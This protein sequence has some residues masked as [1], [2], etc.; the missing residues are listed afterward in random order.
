MSNG[1]NEDGWKMWR[2][3]ELGHQINKHKGLLGILPALLFMLIFFLGGS[4]HSVTLSL[5]SQPVH[6]QQDQFWAYKE[7]LNLSFFR[8]VGITVGMAAAVAVFSGV[9]GLLAAL[10]L[11]E[12]FRQWKWLQIIFQLPIGIPHL[13]SAYLLMQVFMQSGWYSRMAYHFGW[14]DS[15]ESFPVLVHDDWGI[16]VILAYMWKEVPFIVLLIYPFIV[17]LISDWKETAMV[18][19]G[20]FFQTVRWVIVP[21]LLPMWVGGMWV[22]FAFT[23][24]AYEIPALLA[25]T[26][27]G[28]IPVMAFQEY[29]QFGLE[30]QPLAIA[31][32]LV[33][34]AISLLV[35]CLLIYLQLGWYKKGRRVW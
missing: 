25:K 6:G 22:V 30:R 23:L 16:G 8:S 28:S 26:S 17:K 13:L 18:L 35:G 31:M 12:R 14:I 7:L 9:T 15:F 10:L 5:E 1:W 21:I 27:F 29:S 11:A 4:I 19:G 2:I 32:N 3:N 24:G 20:S 33:L 34:A